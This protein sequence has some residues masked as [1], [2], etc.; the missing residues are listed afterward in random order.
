[1]RFELEALVALCKERKIRLKPA[2]EACGVKYSTIHAKI[3]NDRGLTFAEV[4]AFRRF[5]EVPAEVFSDATPR[6][7]IDEERRQ[8]EVSKAAATAYSRAL[9][10]VQTKILQR[11]DTLD[12]DTVLNW[13]RKEGGVLRNFDALKDRIDL[14][15]PTSAD[16]KIF[17]IHKLG[18][19]SLA[20]REFRVTDN[21]QFTYVV[22]NEFSP[23]LA[24]EITADHKAVAKQGYTVADKTFDQIIGGVRVREVYRRILHPVRDLSGNPLVLNFSQLIDRTLLESAQNVRG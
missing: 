17:K 2:C 21:D 20:A 16:D 12:T 7:K 3:S 6:I 24:K 18:T 5:F 8:T 13:L 1:M 11:G 19:K 15:K 4:D 14:F 9:N 10:D 23:E 22:E